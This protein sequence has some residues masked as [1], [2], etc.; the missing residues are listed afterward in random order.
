MIPYTVI[1]GLH[2]H[3]NPA[4]HSTEVLRFYYQL[5]IYIDPWPGPV[6]NLHQRMAHQPNQLHEHHVIHRL[7]S[8]AHK[9]AS[10]I[11]N[12]ELSHMATSEEPG[13]CQCSGEFVKL[14]DEKIGVSCGQWAGAVYDWCFVS[15]KSCPD[16]HLFAMGREWGLS[17]DLFWEKCTSSGGRA[18]DGPPGSMTEE[19]IHGREVLWGVSTFN[20]W[21]ALVL[22]IIALAAPVFVSLLI[23]QRLKA[24]I[25]NQHADDE[26]NANWIFQGLST[27]EIER[28]HEL[29][30]PLGWLISVSILYIALRPLQLPPLWSAEFR[31]LSS[32]LT[33]P[34]RLL[35]AVPTDFKPI[36][37]FIGTIA[38][39]PNR[40]SAAPAPAS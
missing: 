6:S 32:S 39:F 31:P 40:D 14:D 38:P 34:I 18:F 17:E 7:G 27:K 23:R 2:M 11:S 30:S 19:E 20:L 3:R 28:L 10:A 35:T 26:K 4:Q 21:I 22:I 12:F 37:R 15:L 29:A 33:S 8:V 25:T 9:L 5:V 13:E 1:S 36:R 24:Y 16:P